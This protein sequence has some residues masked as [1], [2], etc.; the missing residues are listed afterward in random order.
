[1]HESS[2]LQVEAADPD[3]G[4]NAAVRLALEESG[5]A[6]FSLDEVTGTLCLE[7]PL[8]F[9]QTASYH[10]QVFATDGGKDLV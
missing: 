4:V 5:L 9:E 1:M 7:A 3:C 8:D 10:L 6:M 2:K